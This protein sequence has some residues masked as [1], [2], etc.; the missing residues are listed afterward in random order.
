LENYLKEGLL[1]DNP[2]FNKKNQ[3]WV[4]TLSNSGQEDSEYICLKPYEVFCEKYILKGK[5]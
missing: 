1:P 2:Y 4:I 5:K 3:R